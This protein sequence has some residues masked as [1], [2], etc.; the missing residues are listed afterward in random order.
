MAQRTTVTYVDDLDGSEIKEGKGGPV[1]F[2]FDGAEYVVDLSDKNRKD[3]EKVLTPYLNVAT[4]HRG[5]RRATKKTTS[6][7]DA[8]KVRAWA[9]D[10]GYD[11]PE[12]G[13]IPRDLKEAYQNA[14]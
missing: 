3:L 5:A 4:P 8:A 10:N 14:R 12:R 13:R 7:G 9:K 6:S 2:G 1:V 11:V